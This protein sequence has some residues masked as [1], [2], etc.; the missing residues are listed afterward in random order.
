VPIL[1]GGSTAF[2]NAPWQPGIVGGGIAGRGVQEQP[3]P[4]VSAGQPTILDVPAAVR[5]WTG[6]AL[7][8]GTALTSGNANTVGN[9]DA[10]VWSV[11]A[12]PTATMLTDGVEISGPNTSIARFDANRPESLYSRTQVFLKMLEVPTATLAFATV[13]TIGGAA[14]IGSAVVYSDGK[15]G[16]TNQV[17]ATVAPATSP[18]ALIVGHEYRCDFL[19]V[20]GTTTANGRH[21]ASFVDLDDSTWNGT[22]EFYYES[23]YT[24]NLGVAPAG[25]H[26][27]GK[28]GTGV[29]T[30]GMRIRQV[31]WGELYGVNP[32]TSQATTRAY[33]FT[34]PTLG[35]ST[36]IIPGT[37]ALAGSGTLAVTGTQTTAPSVGMAGSGTLGITATAVQP[38]SALTDSFTGTTIDTA[39][40]TASAGITQSGT[41]TIPCTSSYPALSSVAK[42]TI[43]GS[44]ASVQVVQT[45][46]PG[47]GTCETL[48][49]VELDATNHLR[50]ERVGGSIAWGYRTGGVDTINYPAWDASLHKWWR[51]TESAGTV[52][53]QVSSTGAAWTTLGTIAT[54]SWASAPLTVSLKSG[55]YGT[56]TSPQPAIYDNLNVAPVMPTTTAGTI[57]TGVW[58]PDPTANITTWQ[59][60]LAAYDTLVGKRPDQVVFYQQWSGTPAFPSAICDVIIGRGQIPIITWEPWL[61]TGGATQSTYSLGNIIAGNFDTYI[62]SWAQAAKAYGQ[63]VVLRF[64]HEMNGN[65]YPWAEGVNGNTA[66]QYI[67][68]WR[69]VRDI[70]TAQG[71][72]NVQWLWCPNEP[73]PG[74]TT[75]IASLYPGSSYVDILGVDGYA[76]STSWR[77]FDALMAA[78]VDQ[79]RAVD[80]THPL[81][82]VETGAV[83]A[84]GSKSQWIAD[85]FTTLKYRT[86]IT[87]VAWWHDTVGA[88]A[89]RVDTTTGATSAFVAGIADARYAAGVTA[90]VVQ[91]ATVGMVGSGTLG[92]VGTPTRLAAV[93]LAG[94][95]TLGVTPSVA[96]PATVAL[97]GAGTLAV[98]PAVTRTGV[99]SLAGSGSLS[100]TPAVSHPATV[101]LAGAGVLG[102]LGTGTSSATVPMIGAGTL[103]VTST[104]TRTGIVS[105]VGA[106]TLG[107]TADSLGTQS[108][109]VAMTGVSTLSVAGT[110]TISSTVAMS[111]T[112]TL[113]VSAAVTKLGTI[114]LMGTGSLGV[115]ASVTHP[116]GV[117]MVGSG[118]L[119]VTSI[120][121]QQGIIALAGAGTISVTGTRT[122]PAAVSLVGT[123]SLSVTGSVTSN[124]TLPFVGVGILTT[125]GALESFSTISIS[126]SSSLVV[127]GTAVTT[128]AAALLGAGILSVTGEADRTGPVEL[129]GSGALSV[130]G[131]L[132]GNVSS[133]VALAGVGELAVAARQEGLASLLLAGVGILDVSA[134]VVPLLHDVAITLSGPYCYRPELSGPYASVV[135]ISG[136]FM[137]RPELRGPY[138]ADLDIVGPY[139]YPFSILGPLERTK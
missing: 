91:S 3:D 10:V 89:Y 46:G 13:R 95:S 20:V 139:S 137:S 8:Q 64:A 14:V 117:P 105:M 125:Q 128:N 29:L 87:G 109:V 129:T 138:T 124:A 24:L 133:A 27:I 39:K 32:D 34:P 21:V 33:F 126:G 23:G 115:L 26:R 63:P 111:G 103:A 15:V 99:V 66:G 100:V 119:G 93:A 110:D 11:S 59:T 35:T 58:V 90:A 44:A 136:P 25:Q 84:G 50:M 48:F 55:Y 86:E 9:G 104:L 36:G 22:G 127:G 65:W 2:G 56:E 75:T 94:S 18:V 88:N 41:L 17:A 53:F 108:A 7:P 113:A 42:Y 120:P 107:V 52:S 12:G 118:T 77:T 106:G 62:T 67:T 5:R 72:T 102:V 57:H 76:T 74:V 98:T 71:V 112:S 54:P 92:A 28:V 1:A 132:I 121:T 51:I 4:H 83:E 85:M 68:A 70:F 38:A 69:H 60:N 122:Q 101:A 45:A 43:T 61:Y 40:W 134:T 19:D 49:Q 81:W 131:T 135:T 97:S 82:V 116:A 80:A 114:V 30:T 130:S 123:S 79:I 16:F 47:T 73:Y 96:H 6:N 37:I 31:A 78:A